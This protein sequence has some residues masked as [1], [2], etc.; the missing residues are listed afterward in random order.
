MRHHR[1]QRSEHLLELDSP[2]RI[3]L[4]IKCLAILPRAGQIMTYVR[5]D[6]FPAQGEPQRRELDIDRVDHCPGHLTR[7]DVYRKSTACNGMANVT[8]PVRQHSGNRELIKS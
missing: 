6:R 2:R 4:F 5:P 3:K 8:D 7:V 1:S